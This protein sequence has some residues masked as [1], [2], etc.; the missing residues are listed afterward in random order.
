M[1]DPPTTS[2]RTTDLQLAAFLVTIGHPLVGVDGPAQRR[3]FVFDAVPP[4]TLADY[5]G[6]E[7]AVRPR[8]LFRAYRALKD[9]LF[10]P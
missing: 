1:L 5:Y 9:R 8:E 6:G 4:T 3:I 2:F 10:T 7:H